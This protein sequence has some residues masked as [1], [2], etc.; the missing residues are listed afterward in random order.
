VNQPPVRYATSVDG[1]RIAYTT[2]G[3]GE[4]VFMSSPLTFSHQALE[5]RI[6]ELAGFYDR[7]AT[8][9]TLVRWDPRR[10]GLSQRGVDPEGSLADEMATDMLCVADDLGLERFDI[11]ALNFPAG[12]AVA[13]A[14]PARVRS[15]LLVQP[16][17]RVGELLDD[18]DQKAVRSLAKQNWE[19]FTE[20]LAGFLQGWA[21]VPSFPYADFIRESIDQAD[22]LKQMQAW[23]TIDLTERLARIQCPTMILTAAEGSGVTAVNR[24]QSIESAAGIP[25]ATLHEVAGPATPLNPAFAEAVEEF[26]GAASERSAAGSSAFRTVLFTDVVDHT[27]MMDRLGDDRGRAVLREH[28]TIIRDALHAHRGT[29]VKS[30]GDGFMASFDSVTAAVDCAISLQRRL[31]EHNAT[32]DEPLGVRVGLNAGEPIAED[33]DL[34]GSTVILAARIAACAG[35]GEILV[36]EAV[37]HLLAGKHYRYHDR[38]ETTLKGFDEPVHLYR[39]DWALLH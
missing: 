19:V 37:R 39:V 15:L 32:A 24:R 25:G 14:H 31:G 2:D 8:N 7:V 34:F 30:M 18:P 35:S 23:R 38:G 13:A 22:Y 3:A 27:T 10:Y 5:R 11:V 21:P 9:R 29:E 16:L 4:P 26:L 33:G 20:T 6:P 1:V 12:I 28:E 17:I 36:P